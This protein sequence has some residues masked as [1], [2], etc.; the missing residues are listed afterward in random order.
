MKQRKRD[1]GRR[2]IVFGAALA[3][4]SITVGQHQASGTDRRTVT[5]VSGRAFAYYSNV[6]LSGEPAT[7]RGPAGTT[8]CDATSTTACSPSV[9][10]ASTGGGH[11]AEDVEG[12]SARY[13]RAVIFESS[14]MAAQTRGTT[15]QEG[16]VTSA[17]RASSVGPGP[18][19]A[20]VAGSTCTASG[21]GV[22]ASVS[23]VQGQLVTKT[24]ATTGAPVATQAIDP[25]PAPGATYTGTLD[26]VGGSFKA[27]FN[28]QVRNPDGSITVN[29]LHLSMLGPTTVGEL[30]VA[31]SACGVT[32]ADVAQARSSAE[33]PA[34]PAPKVAAA[35]PAPQAASS[36][37]PLAKVSPAAAATPVALPAAVP[38]GGT[39]AFGFYGEVGLFGGPANPKGPAPNVTLPAGG[40]STP[41]TETVPTGNVQ[42]GPATLF[43]SGPITATASGTAAEPTG[44]VEIQNLNTSGVE[45]LTATNLSSTCTG[46]SGSATVTGGQLRTSEGDPN[47][48]GDDTNE[49]IPPNPAPNTRI[50]GK[51][52]AVGDNFEAIFNEQVASGGGI[53]VTAYHLKLLGPTAVGDLYVGQ[54]RCAAASTGTGTVAA[55]TGTAGGTGTPA[56]G[57]GA[58]GGARRTG[59]GMATTGFGGPG[60]LLLAVALLALGAASSVGGARRRTRARTEHPPDAGS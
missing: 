6:S 26:H 16:L 49:P 43:T 24:D 1:A 5:A 11:S 19:T 34:S 15:G 36:G 56:A 51:I 37:A 28:E 52:E 53:T 4:A 20:E 8:A 13:G 58:T 41:V 30:V 3:T 38:S 32:S 18:F 17:A 47:R 14:S 59:P 48:E 27:V 21:G 35:A 40:S 55:G 33:T 46:G 42:Y 54:S 31:Q 23:I 12:G 50:T 25:A 45:V 7:P 60:P 10:L 39:G 29:A 22:D 9:S 57:A 2:W 44:K